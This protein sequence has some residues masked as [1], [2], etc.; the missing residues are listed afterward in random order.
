MEAITTAKLQRQ[1]REGM[2]DSKSPASRGRA[3]ATRKS[4]SVIENNIS[5]GT[6]NHV[7]SAV[8][9]GEKTCRK[10]SKELPR[11]AFQVDASMPDYLS[12]MCKDCSRR[13][14]R[15]SIRM[16][17]KPFGSSTKADN[18]QSRKIRLSKAVMKNDT[19]FVSIA[20]KCGEDPNVIVRSD[21]SISLL[22]QAVSFKREDM[23]K[24]L[25]E[26][27]A[28]VNLASSD[29]LTPLH[30]AAFHGRFVSCSKNHQ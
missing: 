5:Q 7:P 19:D 21:L 11:T 30:R 17:I 8:F 29:G 22:H 13:R 1:S 23:V 26:N 2:P 20:L 6:F 25:I 16:G 3:G 15:A 14:T 4:Y 28:D 27:G 24:I 10:C 9:E 18:P 12:S